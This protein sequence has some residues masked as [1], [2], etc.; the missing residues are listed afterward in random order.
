MLDEQTKKEFI[1]KFG[2]HLTSLKKEKKLSFRQIASKCDLDSSFIGKISK[3]SENI[4]LETI[5][6][7]LCGLDIQPKDLFDFDF[8]LKKDDVRK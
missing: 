4:T 5:L 7:L 3:G 8:E 2:E 6:N 1:A